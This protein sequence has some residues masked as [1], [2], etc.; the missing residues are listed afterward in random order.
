MKKE[1]VCI[2]K[3]IKTILKKVEIKEGVLIPD[4]KPDI[5][6]V[7]STSENVYISKEI[8]EDGRVKVDGNLESVIIYL[9][10]DAENRS[11]KA[12]LSFS[13][14]IEDERIRQESIISL[15]TM[16]ST[17]DVKIL[18]ERKIE[19]SACLILKLEIYKDEEIEILTNLEDKD[20][21]KQ[22]RKINIKN[23]IARGKVNNSLKE[24]IKTEDEFKILEI[25]KVDI[26]IKN[27]ET[28]MSFN[29]VLAK[30]EVVIKV[31]YIDENKNIKILENSFPLIT[32]IDIEKTTENY[33]IELDYI[34]RNIFFK[35]QN[36][37]NQ[38][39]FQID[40]EIYNILYEVRELNIIEDVYSLDKELE[41]SKTNLDISIVEVD[42][43]ESNIIRIDE[44]FKITDIS[45]LLDYKIKIDSENLNDVVVKNKEYQVVVE[46]LYL[47]TNK[48]IKEEKIVIPFIYKGNE[49][50]DNFSFEIKEK[51][52]KIH[53]DNINISLDIKVNKPS[54]LRI[55][56]SII[57]NI[58]EKDNVLKDDYNFIV[59]YI[60]EN[61][62]L[63]EIAKRFNTT[64]CNL[65]EFNEITDEKNLQI[66]EKIYIVR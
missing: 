50:L 1:K 63:W 44:N 21:E 15:K 49:A 56:T 32:F 41:I 37:G 60:K 12:N 42:I 53:G 7:I 39:D 40:F 54:S 28:K 64:V 23:I 65:K 20:Y 34:V 31:L 61:D 6:N 16:I 55:N 51:S 17:V 3:N 62:S 24:I 59:Y 4:I 52:V 46:L 47:S 29:K 22:E 9:S 57:D 5:V 11:V 10:D 33:N 43:D 58:L 13:E 66:G 30:A 26:E 45:E 35:I 25:F 27:N 18:N 38:I 36:E 2:N 8:V 19:V 14:V 48:N